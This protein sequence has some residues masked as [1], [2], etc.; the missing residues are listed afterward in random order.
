MK[1]AVTYDNG[2]VFQHFGHTKEFKIY[3]I[4]NG[5]IKSSQVIDT[6][7][8]GHGALAGFLQ[9][10][11]IDILICGGIGSGAQEAL[12]KAG[13]MLFGGVNG[14]VDKAVKDYI[15][16]N[17]KYDPL[18]ECSNHGENEEHNCGD[19]GRR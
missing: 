5:Q 7:G 2:K 1:I 11:N 8:K 18:V 6:N 12:S 15:S 16:G 9:S 4:D 19:A 10:D 17:L 14:D 13:I 3:D